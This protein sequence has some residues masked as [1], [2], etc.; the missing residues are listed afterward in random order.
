MTT[1]I[2]STTHAESRVGGWLAPEEFAI[3][4]TV[5]ETLF[6]SLEP[7]AGSSEVEQAYYRRN[8]HDLH[9]ANLIAETLAQQA[10]EVQTDFRQLLALMASSVSGLLLAG[11]AKSFLGLSPEKRARYLL[12]MANSPLGQ[13]RQGYQAIKRLAG[14]IY[15]SAPTEEGRNPNWE[16]LDYTPASPP[17]PTDGPQP[18]RPLAITEDT[19]LDA[20]AIVIGSGA[21][22]GV[23]AAELALAGKSVI[24]LEKGGYNNEANFTLQ[25][26]QATPELY[27]NRG[28][29]TSKD[30]GVVVLAG[31]T[32]GGGTVVNW[33]TSFRTPMDVLEEWE[34]ISGLRDRFTN[35][36]YQKSF[37]AV[38]Q[39]IQVNTENSAHNRQNRLLYD[40]CKALDYHAEAIPRNAVGCDQRCGTCGYG[41]RYGAKQSTMKTYLQDAFDHGARIIVNCQADK[42][43]MENGQVRG[44]LATVHNKE[45][46]HAYELTLHAK[47][48]VV[49]AGTLNTPAILLRSGLTNKHI[50]QHLHLH[51]TTTLAGLYPD[52]VYPWQ[53]VMQ[54]A[55]SDQF[56]HL[57]ANYGYK[58]EVPPT[59]PGLL[60]LATPWFSARE[61]RE[62]MAQ[63]AHIATMIVLSRDKGEGSVTLDRH[64]EPI[65]NYVVSVYDRKH[66]M[67][68]LRQSARVH[69]AA[70]A[71]EVVTLHNQRT[72]VKRGSDGTVSAQDLR[73]FDRAI[74]RHGMGANRNMTFT[75]HQMGT[76][77]M[78][79]DPKASVTNE[80]GEV[81]GV[82][83][84][85]VA[86]GSLFPAASGVNPML[87]IM[88][89]VHN[90]CQ[91]LKSIV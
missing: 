75:A 33:T 87:S 59:H 26:A 14:F 78:G 29:L 39:R 49:A 5:C 11:S 77:R 21:G 70:G 84:L 8:A 30:L 3:L 73:A 40:G 86:D 32:L 58:L 63:A 44:V 7:P 42:V 62:Q 68:G 80:H 55:Y 6:P 18:I 65:I 81:Y 9:L 45:T 16:A 4:E 22:G 82:K 13:L 71:R 2:S 89:L 57:D 27:L 69:F 72:G 54:S 60:G 10:P 31:S 90:N 56:S 52:K 19:T 51:P 36:Q 67:H 76:C 64:G 28:L 79:N 37:A 53:G 12:A 46:G 48:V 88:A 35:A 61:Y 17:P 15:F 91:Y 20:D 43:L 47:T 1:T 66:L 50:G 25:E 23:A 41:C 38:E 74:E 85:F 83:G 34:A 24:L